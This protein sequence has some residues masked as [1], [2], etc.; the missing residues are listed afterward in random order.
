MSFSEVLSVPNV[1]VNSGC[2]I[3]TTHTARYDALHVKAL[4]LI[5]VDSNLITLCDCTEGIRELF[6]AESSSIISISV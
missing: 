3:Q 2:V 6:K 4:L 1:A 5:S